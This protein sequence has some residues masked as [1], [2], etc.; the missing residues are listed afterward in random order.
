MKKFLFITLI[1][2]LLSCNSGVELENIPTEDLYSV[3]SFI[4]PQDTLF[5]V[6]LFH[7]NAIG[8]IDNPALAL[9]TDAEVVIT[10]G[11][12]QFDT[13]LFN[14][15]T[16]RYEAR[17][18]N[19]AVESLKTYFLK[20]KLIKGRNLEASCTIPPVPGIPEVTGAREN[21]DYLFQVSWNN[22]TSFKYFVLIPFG[23]GFYE[24]TTP[25]GTRKEQIT[26]RLLDD[27]RFPSDDQAAFNAYEGIVSRAYLA[28][29]PRLTIYLRN[30]EANLYEY[31]KTYQYFDGWDINNEGNLFPNFRDPEPVFSNIEGGV[32]IFAGYNQSIKT[33]QID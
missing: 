1:P 23:E 17:K 7:A 11:V 21:D 22:P 15:D 33:Y 4:S 24:R 29:N 19:V 12:L 5:R 9:V 20:I 8:T 28:D 2:V 6:Y 14:K 13:L 32:G 26:A 10:D 25:L 18:K 3:S 16:D 27:I 30:V 31:F